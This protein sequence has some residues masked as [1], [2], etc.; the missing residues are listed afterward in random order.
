MGDVMKQAITYIRVSTQKQSLGLDAQM[1]AITRFA[2]Q[3]GY[4]V[5]QVFTEKQSGGDDDTK[6]PQLKAALAAAK[7]AKAPILVAKL[8]RLS[9][10]VHFISGLMKHKIPFI[11][12]ELGADTDPFMLHL[13]AAF[14]EKERRLISERT[15]AAL[16]MRKAA[17]K[18][19]GGGLNEKGMANKAEA[20]ERAEE[21]RPVF[22]ELAGCSAR[23]IARTLNERK[24]ATPSGAPWSAVTVLRVRSRL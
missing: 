8:C 3:E 11:V 12:A 9:R 21:L 5:A 13:Y 17:G 20:K 1:S 10:D 14:A 15:K 16:A 24:I 18:A 19:H 6:R 2:E 4:D 22:E 7:K 23:E